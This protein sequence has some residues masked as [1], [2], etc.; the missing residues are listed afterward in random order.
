MLLLFCKIPC[1]VD[2]VPRRTMTF[3]ALPWS[4]DLMA[5]K[6]SLSVCPAL[7]RLVNWCR[8]RSYPSLS[9]C[10]SLIRLVN[11]CRHRSY[12]SLSVCPL[13]RLVNW[14]RHRSYPSLSVCPLIR[15]VNW[16]RHRSYPSLSVC[17]L[18]R[19]VNWCRHRS[20]PSLPR[21]PLNLASHGFLPAVTLNN[22]WVTVR[23]GQ[24][25]SRWRINRRHVIDPANCGCSLV[26]ASVAPHI[27]SHCC[28]GGSWTNRG[29]R[30]QKS[31]Q[32]STYEAETGIDW[33]LYSGPPG[34][35][36]KQRKERTPL[37]VW[38][39]SQNKIAWQNCPNCSCPSIQ[40]DWH[41]RKLATPGHWITEN[42]SQVTHTKHKLHAFLNWHRHN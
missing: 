5:S 20:Y 13:I 30:V 21:S 11:W 19:L 10:P 15:L 26:A 18:I 17:P 25:G 39:R 36:D 12:P 22:C 38:Q 37:S 8:H 34:V 1:T 24:A 9:V 29:L 14:C 16:C 42:N 28:W 35:K 6:M 40:V 23:P 3:P 7:I 27:G 31:V 32:A 33:S 41:W 2:S 4:G